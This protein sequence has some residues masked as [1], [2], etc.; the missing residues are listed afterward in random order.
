ML[1]RKQNDVQPQMKRNNNK[2]IT[3]NGNKDTPYLRTKYKFVVQVDDIKV[4]IRLYQPE[5]PQTY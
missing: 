3:L 1:T 5:M 2:T 4:K